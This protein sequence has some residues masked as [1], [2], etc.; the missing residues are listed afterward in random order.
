MSK[1]IRFLAVVTLLITLVP[2]S[3]AHTVSSSS[4]KKALKITSAS[5]ETDRQR[6]VG[7]ATICNRTAED[8]R[9]VL[10]VKNLTIN[11]LYKRKLLIPATKC[12]T[13]EL[14]FAK[15]FAEMSNTG[16]EILLQAK[17]VRG[18]FSLGKYDLSKP[19][20]TVVTEG[21]ED[22]SGCGD[23]AGDDGFYSPC[24]GDFIYHEPSGLRIKLTSTDYRYALIYVTHI[25]WGGVK[26]FRIYKNRDREVVSGDEDHTKVKIANVIGENDG[27]FTFQVTSH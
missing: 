19:Y 26:Q 22:L 5:F 21:N 6:V 10:D 27:D 2:I 13:F 3:F 18:I 9:F 14:D 24:V 20:E 17:S 12:Q 15:N 4:G 8:I 11:G 7:E 16:D 25:R 23:A 1:F